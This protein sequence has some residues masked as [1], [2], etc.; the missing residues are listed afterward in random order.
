MKLKKVPI[1]PKWGS[2]TGTGVM[3]PAKDCFVECR[4]KSNGGTNIR[5]YVNIS[6]QPLDCGKIRPMAKLVTYARI[7]PAKIISNTKFQLSA[8]PGKYLCNL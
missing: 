3:C 2:L 6:T 1:E 8:N 7:L 4:I 5:G